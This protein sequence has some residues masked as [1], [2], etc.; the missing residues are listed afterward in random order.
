ML[1]KFFHL[2]RLLVI[3]IL[4]RNFAKDLWAF[5]ST[6]RAIEERAN[7]NSTILR[8]QRGEINTE[9]SNFGLWNLQKLFPLIKIVK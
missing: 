7:R 6:F 4:W 3:Q 8:I 9:D 1:I 2:L 5:L